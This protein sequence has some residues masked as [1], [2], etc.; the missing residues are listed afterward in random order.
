MKRLKYLI[1]ALGLVM[2]HGAWAVTLPSTSYTPYSASEITYDGMESTG[3]QF[4]PMRFSALGSSEWG[5]ACV[6]EAG[7]VGNI[8]AC[9]SCCERKFNECCPNGE[10][11]D[12]EYEQCKQLSRDCNNECGRSLP[13]DG[14]EWVLILLAAIAMI[15]E[16]KFLIRLNK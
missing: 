10:C 2:A 1:F 16:M 7:G 6:A 5:D 14:G 15:G 8:S 4:S 3:S 13:L 12:E 11:E 9:Q